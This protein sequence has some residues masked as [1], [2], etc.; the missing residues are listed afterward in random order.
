MN[1]QKNFQ[2]YKYLLKKIQQIAKQVAKIF[3]HQKEVRSVVK[4]DKRDIKLSADLLGESK[5]RTELSKL[6]TWPIIGEEQGG[7][8]ALPQNNIPY[9]II[10]PL[11]GTFNYFRNFPISCISIGAFKGLEPLFGVVYD[12]N[13][14]E[15]FS[16]GPD[17]PFCIN[18][19]PVISP[20]IADK[21]EAIL[22]TGFP[23]LGPKNIQ[24]IKELHANVQN[25]RKIRM[26]GSAALSLAYTA[27]GRCDAYFER[28]IRLWDIAAGLALLKSVGGDFSI[29]ATDYPLAYKVFACRNPKWIL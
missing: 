13:R 27:A 21:S 15:C 9:W 25:Y 17:L 8:E 3:T 18:N 12:F 1:S 16:G 20:L 23:I 11:D 28:N 10:D 5:I 4:K 2:E 29:E 6:N 26:I 22:A 19:K 7:D 14:N 24:F